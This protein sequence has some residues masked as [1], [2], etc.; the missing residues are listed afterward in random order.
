MTARKAPARGGRRSGIVKLHR[1]LGLV[2]AAFWLLQ[3][4]TGTLI[5]FHWEMRDAAISDIHRPT[6][7]AGIERRLAV[8]APEGTSAAI[9]SMWTTA[10]LPDR[11]DIYYTDADGAD[12]SAR[13][14][15]DGTV[16]GGTDTLV[17]GL[18]DTMVGLHHDLLSGPTGDWIVAISGSLLVS[19]LIAGLIVAWPR[20]GT[21]S[22]AL[23]PIGKGPVAARLYSWH[24]AAGLWLVLPM[25]LVA[26]TGT[27]LKFPDGVTKLLGAQT[28]SLPAVA[29]AGPP[30]GF[31]AAVAA[32]LK[33]MPGSA[34]VSVS[35]PTA[36]DATYQVRLRT[37]QEMR[38]AYGASRVLI[39][40]ND[41][42]V[43]G[44]FPIVAAST[45]TQA[46][47]A[48]VPIH[49]GQAAGLIGRLLILTIGLCL[50]AMIATGLLLWAKRRK[51][52]KTA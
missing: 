21:W 47:N 22:I 50:I 26:I 44:S 37:P 35:F 2:A 14:L 39:D 17:G 43:R 27:L 1:W 19:N 32:A 36:E 5:V 24:R 28:P 23:K 38:H 10:G 11:Y 31:A 13:I 48:I 33:T 42:T 3:A 4:V 52:K 25:L 46:F 34:L 18:L 45:G 41:G 20:R 16:L 40:A 51:K 6:D 29:T 9:G 15:G 49:T 12:Q 7:L 30:V 8:L